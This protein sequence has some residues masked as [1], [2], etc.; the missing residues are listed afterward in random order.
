LAGSA[1]TTVQILYGIA[2]APDFARFRRVVPA[3]RRLAS[4]LARMRRNLLDAE[5]LAVLHGD[6]HPGNV[7]FR[8]MRE[9]V[10]LDWARARM[11]SPLEDVSNWLQSLGFWEPAARRR[12]DRLLSRYLRARGRPAN[13]GRSFRE[14]YWLA[15]ASNAFAGAMTYHLCRASNPAMSEEVRRESYWAAWDWGRSIMRADACWTR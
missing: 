3:A 11:G 13:L 12:H 9:P 10:L 2:R 6:A 15:R 14:L 1:V 7:V 5:R 8:R 4:N